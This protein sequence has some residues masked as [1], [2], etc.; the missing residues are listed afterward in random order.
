MRKRVKSILVICVIGFLGYIVGTI[1][2]N[3]RNEMMNH[4]VVALERTGISSKYAPNYSMYGFVGFRDMFSQTKF[5]VYYDSDRKALF[6]DIAEAKHWHVAPVTGDEYLRL[7]RACMCN[8][9]IDVPEDVVFDAWYYLETTEPTQ[10]SG[11]APNG[12]LSEI[13]QI[14]RGFEFAVFDLETGLFIF[15]DQFG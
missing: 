5:K 10:Y 9:V 6:N 14:G 11:F 15:V 4:A 12:A 7:Q 13:G 1:D 8:D 3:T 2:A